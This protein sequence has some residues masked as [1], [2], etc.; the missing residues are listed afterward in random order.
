MIQSMTCDNYVVGV[1]ASKQ[2][3]CKFIV[4]S[5]H[6]FHPRTAKGNIQFDTVYCL[7]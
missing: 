1:T 6:W 5:K 3:D 7:W 2:T 4:L